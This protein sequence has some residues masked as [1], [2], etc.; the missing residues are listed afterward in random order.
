MRYFLNLAKTDIP[1]EK[2]FRLTKTFIILVTFFFL[3]TLHGQVQTIRIRKEKLISASFPGGKDS[4]QSY[5]N[6][7][8]TDKIEYMQ[9]VPEKIQFRSWID[10]NSKGE[11]TKVNLIESTG[12]PFIDSTF[13]VAV[14]KMP[15]WEPATNE[16][17][18]KC[19][20]KQFLPLNVEFGLH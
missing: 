11:I 6:R 4:L 13:I 3:T 9:N 19:K 7:T 18:N 8:V 5:F 16:L 20:D 15:D 12:F 2:A 10:I 14:K 17:G 1:L